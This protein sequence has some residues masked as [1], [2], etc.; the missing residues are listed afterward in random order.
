M[1]FMRGTWMEWA[2]SVCSLRFCD[3]VL[4]AQQG[5][6]L[7]LPQGL[8]KFTRG[9]ALQA[10]LQIL[11]DAPT[12]VAAHGKNEGHAETSCVFGIE[13]RQC[14]KFP[15]AA[16]IKPRSGLFGLRG[17]GQFHAH[18]RLAGQF[19]VRPDQAELGVYLT[20]PRSVKVM[21]EVSGQAH[22]SRTVELSPEATL[23]ETIALP[24]GTAPTDVTARVFTTEGHEILSFTPL[25][26]ERPPRPNPA[27]PAPPPADV[28]SNEELYLHGLHLEQYRHATY[29]PEPYYEEALRRDPGDS[30]CH[31]A[32]ARLLWRRGQFAAA[33][34]H[35]RVA[36]E[37]LTLRNPNPYDGEAHYQ[38]GL[39][40]TFQGRTREAFDAFYKATWNA[41]WQDS[42][43][44]QLARLARRSRA[45]LAPDRRRAAPQ[46]LASSG[47][48]PED[49]AVAQAGARRRRGER[50]LRG[51]GARST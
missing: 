35:L 47:P 29:A 3:A 15:R 18:G 42:A 16:L 24:I 13:A 28:A 19:R 37:R 31:V 44:F 8:G 32:L 6:P 23:R 41:A 38:L 26:P 40:L 25:R 17:F 30:R 49:R 51:V 5:D 45:G 39:V 34:S 4:E 11:N 12:R 2:G 46:P 27:T 48:A 22:W 33:E 9:I 20:T 43:F 1:G 36:I 7:D 50:D 14:F 10:T 21:L